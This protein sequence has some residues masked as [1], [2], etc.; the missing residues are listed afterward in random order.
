MTASGAIDADVQGER[1]ATPKLRTDLVVS[2]QS[3][4]GAVS[5]VV[6]EPTSGRIFRFG[7]IEGYLLEQLN[8]SNSL[9]QIQENV[10]GKFNA[11]L[12]LPTLEQFV[13]RLGRLGLLEGAEVVSDRLKPG[14]QAKR[15]FGGNL[16]YLRVKAI[17]PD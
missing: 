1:A 9:V 2:E 5:V 7:E 6:K 17:N 14:P 15:R 11:P 13:Q 16:F 4:G 10:Q 8:G 3:S 12:S